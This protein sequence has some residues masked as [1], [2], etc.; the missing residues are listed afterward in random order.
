MNPN[1]EGADEEDQDDN[2]M[3]ETSADDRYRFEKKLHLRLE[4]E[5]ER[6]DKSKKEVLDVQTI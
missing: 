6:Y 5:F 4:I 3:D 1:N 2:G